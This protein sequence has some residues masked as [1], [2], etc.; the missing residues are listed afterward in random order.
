MKKL[1]VID[2]AH[3][4]KDPGAVGNGLVESKVVCDT[5]PLML[6]IAQRVGHLLRAAGYETIMT[7]EKDVFVTL[8]DRTKIAKSSKSDL[9]VSIHI[10]AAANPAGNGFETW[11]HKQNAQGLKLAKLIQAEFAAIGLR[12]RGIKDSTKLAV[13]NGTKTI[14]S[15]LVECGFISNAEDALKLKDRYWRQRIATAIVA[16][17]KK[18][19]SS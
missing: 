7:R 14:P 10:N 11:Y 12:D 5:N 17:I 16:G 4:G 3:G 13:L 18:F 8:T 9:F 19:Y 15:V 1:I 6:G 2:P